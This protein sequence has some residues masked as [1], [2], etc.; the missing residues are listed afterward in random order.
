MAYLLTGCTTYAHIEKISDNEY[1][2]LQ[3]DTFLFLTSASVEKCTLSEDG[4]FNCEAL[5][6]KRKKK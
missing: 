4:R 2:L 5:K 3:N 6:K 1:L